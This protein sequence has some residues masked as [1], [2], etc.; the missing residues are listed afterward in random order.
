MHSDRIAGRI[1]DQEDVA[2]WV[3]QAQAL[4]D[5]EEEEKYESGGNIASDDTGRTDDPVRMYLREMGTVEL[6][7]REGEI[8]IAKRIEAGREMMIGGICES[9]LAIESLI[10]WYDSLQK[11]DILLREVIDLDATYNDGPEIDHSAKP[12][13]PVKPTA[14]TPAPAKKEGEEATDGDD[15]S[16]DEAEEENVS[17][18]AME[19]ELKPKVFEVFLS[20]QSSFFHL[21]VLFCVK[22]R[23]V[24]VFHFF[25]I[26]PF[27]NTIENRFYF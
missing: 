20:H 1:L 23:F 26:F 15:N 3:G 4:S 25:F 10:A 16:G 2:P 5:E 21:L 12:R 8:A 22:D 18:A 19:E 6:L 14:P 13:P 24:F 9:P 27:P 11:G 7:S 17:L